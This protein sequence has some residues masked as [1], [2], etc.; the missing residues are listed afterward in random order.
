MVM[1]IIV[2]TYDRKEKFTHENAKE[3]KIDNQGIFYEVHTENEI[4]KYKLGDVERVVI[5]EDDS[6]DDRGIPSR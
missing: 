6:V 3:E 1:R 4:I 2:M 5:L